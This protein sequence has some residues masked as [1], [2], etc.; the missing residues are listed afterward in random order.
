M[1]NLKWI[2]IVLIG[3]GILGLLILVYIAATRDLSSLESVLLQIILL[4]IGSSISFFA[5]HRSAREAAEA[6]IKPHA[7]SAFRR[8]LSLYRSLSRAANAIESSQSSESD[9]DYQV[10]LARL[11]EIVAYQ[12][13]TADDALED[14]ND[15]VPEDVKELEQKLRPDNATED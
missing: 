10:V 13:M 5:G 4:A 7:R 9:G 6:I 8:L 2:V 12:L 1:K 14:W 11:E 15:I 3:L